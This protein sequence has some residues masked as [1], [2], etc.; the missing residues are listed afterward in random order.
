MSFQ[1]LIINSVVPK[2][3]ILELVLFLLYIN[4]IQQALPNGHTYLYA[5]DTRIFYQYKEI[6]EN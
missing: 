2:G 5:D 1:K 4:D 6:S 3:S